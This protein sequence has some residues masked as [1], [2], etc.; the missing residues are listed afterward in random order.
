MEVDAELLDKARRIGLEAWDTWGNWQWGQPE[1][2]R[3]ERAID[4]VS[5]WWAN[6]L[7]SEPD[8]NRAIKFEGGPLD[9]E[10][11]FIRHADAVVL[12]RAP[13]QGP[14]DRTG[15]LYKWSPTYSVYQFD[16]TIP[17]AM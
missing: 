4:A 9:G 1:Q 2:P 8:P 17:D 10:S 13:D 16:R 15:Y 5:N 6:N 14:L 12:I 3:L 7:F 11:R